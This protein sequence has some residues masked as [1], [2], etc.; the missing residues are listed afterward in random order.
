MRLRN[1]VEALHSASTSP[2]E[3]KRP[4]PSE[5]CSITT[6]MVCWVRVGKY[7]LS[8]RAKTSQFELMGI[9]PR[10]PVTMSRNGNSE[11]TKKN[12]ICA[13]ML[14]E[15]SLTQRSKIRRASTPNC[16]LQPNTRGVR[17]K[18]FVAGLLGRVPS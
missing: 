18:V 10:T 13:A 1:P 5:S 16:D 11:S 6:S 2:T 17:V 14:M 7:W 8:Q 4:E 9:H 15:S 3:K 12:D